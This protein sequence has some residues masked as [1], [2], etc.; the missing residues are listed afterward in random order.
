MYDLPVNSVLVAIFTIF[1]VTFVKVLC[2]IHNDPISMVP[3][4]WLSRWTGAVAEYH[5]V[6]G[7][8]PKYVHNLHKKY[9]PIV[10]VAPD[11]IDI[12]DINAHSIRRRLLSSPMSDTSLQ[13]MQ[14]TIDMNIQ[15]AIRQMRHE[16]KSRGSIDIFKWWYL[17]STDLI[18]QLTFGHTFQLLERGQKNQLAA[19][20]ETL[21][22]LGM[23][24]SA[25]PTLL[26]L[27]AILPLPY[28]WNAMKAG[29]RIAEYADQ[30]LLA[31]KTSVTRDAV[32][33][34]PTLFTN[35]SMRARIDYRT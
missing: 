6:M 33:P 15:L 34:K 21:P 8:R 25:F 28:F 7:N 23:I 13:S 10:R 5:W 12:C 3:R 19:D 32:N 26:Q 2:P 11:K 4:P 27:A 18:G 1:L 35:Y 20:L 22:R 16:M 29:Q 17:M 9:S 30:S 31:Y 14:P 24:G